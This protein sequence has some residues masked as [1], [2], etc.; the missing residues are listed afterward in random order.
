MFSFLRTSLLLALAAFAVAGCQMSKDGSRFTRAQLAVLTSEGF[1][2]T[3]RGWEFSINDRLLFETDDSNV[4]PEQAASIRRI[5]GRLLAVGIRHAAVEGHA[6][7]TGSTEHNQRLSE[8][9]AA[10]VAAVLVAG[11]FAPA[12]VS[13]VGLGERFPIDSNRT[14]DGRRENRRVVILITAP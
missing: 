10:E 13:A 8:R 5:G 11:G 7:G 14:A 2:E 6:D 3:D 1:T 12:D 9:R 4:R